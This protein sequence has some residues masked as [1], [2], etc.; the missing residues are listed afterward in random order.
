MAVRPFDLQNFQNQ[1]KSPKT[2]LKILLI[3]L[4]MIHPWQV[5]EKQVEV[6]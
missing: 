6:H 1:N 2:P 5:V 4:E 3:L